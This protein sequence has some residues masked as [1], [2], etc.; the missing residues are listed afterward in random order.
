MARILV[1]DDDP[2]FRMVLDRMLKSA[3]HEIISAADG[4]EGLKELGNAGNA[5][6]DLVIV[7]IYMPKKDGVETIIHLRKSNPRI[8]IIA[9]SGNPLGPI[10]L[11]ISEKLGA[12][13][14]LKKP[15][16]LQELLAAV[17][18]ALLSTAPFTRRQEDKL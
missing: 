9:I 1:I 5:V 4:D 11:S 7:D 12:A 15:F 16:S 2:A 10:V 3:R 13:A 8:P 14:I 18:K 6:P 17:D